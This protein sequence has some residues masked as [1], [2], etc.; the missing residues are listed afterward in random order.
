MAVTVMK[1]NVA[2]LL[3]AFACGCA[4]A[5]PARVYYLPLDSDTYGLV[6]KDNIQQWAAETIDIP[7]G[8]KLKAILEHSIVKP[9]YFDAK[10]VRSAVFIGNDKFFVDT[11][12]VV[13]VGDKRYRIDKDA[14]EAYMKSVSQYKDGK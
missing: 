14:F 2:L 4:A 9:A 5:E 12:A 8:A 1:T 6:T 10:L 11:H 7:D 13:E 3:F